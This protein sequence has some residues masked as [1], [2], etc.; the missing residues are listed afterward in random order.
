MPEKGTTDK[1]DLGITNYSN[2][3]L[4]LENQQISKQLEKLQIDTA[5]LDIDFFK[6]EE[7]QQEN[8][9]WFKNET[10]VS[11]D[12]QITNLTI[13]Q[14]S[15]YRDMISWFEQNNDTKT[16]S[17][18]CRF[19]KNSWGTIIEIT[20]DCSEGWS[21]SITARSLSDI[22]YS[23]WCESENETGEQIH[24]KKRA[25][26]I[27]FS[28]KVLTSSNKT[29]N[30]LSSLTDRNSDVH[31]AWEEKGENGEQIIY[32]KNLKQQ[33]Q[34]T[35]IISN[36]SYKAYEPHLGY[37]ED[38]DEVYL[39][40]CQEKSLE[41]FQILYQVKE[42][43][44]WNN[45]AIIYSSQAPINQLALSF[46]NE[47]LIVSWLEDYSSTKIVKS[48]YKK[49]D[50]GV[51]QTLYQT[52]YI[53]KQTIDISRKGKIFNLWIRQNSWMEELGYLYRFNK[54][55][56]PQTWIEED[57]KP[58]QAFVQSDFLEDIHLYYLTNSN[59]KIRYFV[60][61]ADSDGDFLGDYKELQVY[62]TDPLDPD[63][64]EDGLLD[65]E[66][67]YKYYTDPLIS[68]TD[69]DEMPDGYEIE[70]GLDPIDNSDATED[71]DQ[72]GITNYNE[73]YFGFIPNNPDSDNDLLLDGE[74]FYT[75]GT[76]PLNPDCDEDG[77]LDGE[78]I[79]IYGTDP[80]NEDS[81]GDEMVDG[82]EVQYGLNPLNE[83][84]A[85][86]DK[87]K[88]GLSN[89]KEWYFGCDPTN[90]DS[91][92]DGLTDGSE[93]WEYDTHPAYADYDEDGL[94]DFE[95]VIIYGTDSYNNDTDEDQMS[96]G[97]EITYNLDPL[98]DSDADLDKDGDGVKNFEEA[99]LGIQPN[100]T[101]SDKDQLDDGAELYQYLTNPS[102]NDTDE[103][104]CLDGWEVM[105]QFNPLNATDGLLDTDGD[106][107][108]NSKEC[109]YF[110]HPR[111]ADTDNDTLSDGLEVIILHTN[112]LS[113]D[114][115]RD[116]LPDNIEFQIGTN[117]LDMDSDDDEMPDGFEYEFQ[118]D[119]LDEND[120]QLDLDDDRLTNLQEYQ[121]SISPRMNDTDADGLLDGDEVFDFNTSPSLEDSDGDQMPDGW[122]VTF[123]THPTQRDGSAD[124]DNDDLVNLQEWLIGTL[125]NVTDS[126]NDGMTDGYEVTFE[127]N[128]LDPSDAIEDLD[129]DGLSNYEEFI[130]HGHPRQNDTDQD[131]II[132]GQEIK[133]QTLVNNSDTDN[134]QMIDGWEVKFDLN[135]LEASDALLDA[136][137]DGLTNLEEYNFACNPTIKDSDNDG[138]LDGQEV[139]QYG[140]SPID[141]D[142]DDDGFSDGLEVQKGT[143]PLDATNN[144]KTRRQR[145][146]LIM[147]CLLT[148]LI[149]VLIVSWFV[150][151]Q[152]RELLAEA[153]AQKIMLEKQHLALRL[154]QAAKKP[155]IVELI[156]K[157][158]H[159]LYS[160]DKLTIPIK[161]E[162]KEEKETEQSVK[163]ESIEE[164]R[165]RKIRNQIAQE[166]NK[167]ME[168]RK[169]RDDWVKS[170]EELIAIPEEKNR[171]LE[172]E[173]IGDEIK[174]EEK[175]EKD[176]EI[177]K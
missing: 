100:C 16:Q 14:D 74:E 114:T 147:G 160:T 27:W 112:P 159:E 43:D 148:V 66:E 13:S 87:D 111:L 99:L 23:F 174:D 155:E 138:L 144:P 143:N 169:E 108:I 80:F 133:Y 89:Y 145:I 21:P 8:Y 88:D 38:E 73:W 94:N 34:P 168:E 37:N 137:Q 146:F 132:D 50:W 124:L 36:I 3:N 141:A 119:P 46:K 173:Y 47:E 44:S 95:E 7:E 78:E 153:K 31:L 165:K 70:Y 104:G 92:G 164:K 126:D 51:T 135:P 76:Y 115:D 149:I 109:V 24:Y 42:N 98:D 39:V 103:D 57:Q 152:R 12:N 171:Y 167:K 86:D 122:E 81:D 45:P 53:T 84:D 134:D 127:L 163:K 19:L 142:S 64:D 32:Y 175:E 4:S 110:C 40:Y 61:E 58:V 106:D 65:G 102:N 62:E 10:L 82:F 6:A 52:T 130:H 11:T 96:D 161:E 105:Y 118:L 91:D 113:T 9:Y 157:T 139:H 26:G 59:E 90:I 136:D 55:S 5:I 20:S 107:L 28:E 158:F 151:N 93:Y 48:R 125:P 85:Q 29:P 49:E 128:P 83:T 131:W 166:K 1:G 79:L 101:D 121:Y 35:E 170:E 30:H 72:D 33:W 2:T 25:A 56:S 156:E 63:T 69:N 129:N 120:A 75:Y 97:F 18:Y 150:Y 17:L 77:V 116:N 54:W 71:L 15:N 172:I 22:V 123:G 68:D 177:K 60:G 176:N 41:E 140:T 117:P 67:V 162:E 154:E